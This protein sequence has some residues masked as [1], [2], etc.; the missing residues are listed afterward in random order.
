[1]GKTDSLKSKRKSTT[2]SRRSV[3]IQR[4]FH[5]PQFLDGMVTTCWKNPQTCHGGKVQLFW[6]LLMVLLH[7]SDL[8]INH[9]EFLSKMSTKS[10]VLVQCQSVEL[11]LVS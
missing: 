11:K 2:S 8:L 7:Q 10:V 3:T 6:V 9:F 1:M 5:L 4:T